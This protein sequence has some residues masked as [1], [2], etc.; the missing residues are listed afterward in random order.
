MASASAKPASEEEVAELTWL[1]S[2][3]GD[4]HA[5]YTQQTVLAVNANADFANDDQ[6]AAS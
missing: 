1:S 3:K 5:E 4:E 2:I 6:R